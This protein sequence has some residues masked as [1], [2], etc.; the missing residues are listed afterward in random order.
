[1]GPT[2]VQGLLTRTEQPVSVLHRRVLPSQLD[3]NLHM[4]Q[5]VYAEMFEHGRAHWFLRSGAWGRWRAAGCNPVVARQTLTYRRELKPFQR[6]RIETRAVGLEGRLVQVQG[7]LAV[8]RAVHTLAEVRLLLIGPDGVLDPAQTR[9][10][11]ER[12]LTEAARIEDFRL[13]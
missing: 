4:N 6:Y 8:G 5:A 7:V 10:L 1:M 12:E 11:V 9:A 2:I 13:V 3:T